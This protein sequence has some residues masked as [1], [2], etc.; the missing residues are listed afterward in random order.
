MF[1]E[2][3]RQ[4]PLIPYTQSV[5]LATVLSAAGVRNRLVLVNGG[6]DLDFPD[7]YRNLIRQILEFLDA[8]WKDV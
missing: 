7:H 8:T 4:D 6:H 1:L 2:Q 3:G 5:E